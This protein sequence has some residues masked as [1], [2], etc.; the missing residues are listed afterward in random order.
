MEL[1]VIS[2]PL[3][4]ICKKKIIVS[5]SSILSSPIEYLKGVGPQKADL[6]KKEAGIFT[7]NDLLEYYPFRYID[8]TQITP[9][10]IIDPDTDYVQVLGK[11]ISIEILGEKRGRRLVAALQ[12]STGVLDLVWFQGISWIE[13]TLH[14]GSKF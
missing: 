3:Y 6:L 1:K 7:F 14:I 8:K 10:G 4:Y 2:S 5:K 12:D 11:I 13:K 9:I